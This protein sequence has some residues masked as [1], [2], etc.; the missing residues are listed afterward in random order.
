MKGTPTAARSV[1]SHPAHRH[2]SWRQSTQDRRERH[3]Q[4]R[5]LCPPPCDLG[6]C[7]LACEDVARC[8]ASSASVSWCC[9]ARM[10]PPARLMAPEVAGCHF[11][12]TPGRNQ[13]PPLTCEGWLAH[14]LTCEV[15]RLAGSRH[16]TQSRV[17]MCPIASRPTDAPIGRA[18]RASSSRSQVTVPYCQRRGM[19]GLG[20]TVRGCPLASTAVGGDCH[21]VGHS[22]VRAL[23]M[24]LTSRGGAPKTIRS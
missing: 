13:P 12:T 20:Q 11:G 19:L 6:I 15:R 9:V 23:A 5:R 2:R 1:A 14:A 8:L 24:P 10:R 18:T 17:L 21:S 22:V 16:F 4:I 7:L 3:S